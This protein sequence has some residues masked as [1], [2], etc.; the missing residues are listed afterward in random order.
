MGE[1]LMKHPLCA[2]PRRSSYQNPGPPS[3][4]SLFSFNVAEVG[5][6]VRW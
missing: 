3:P 5:S 2:A 1:G 6:N 4:R